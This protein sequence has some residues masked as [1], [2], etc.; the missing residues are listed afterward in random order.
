MD[1]ICSNR[2]RFG[3]IS[4]DTPLYP[5]D[6]YR[7]PCNAK[8][9]WNDSSSSFNFLCRDR[10]PQLY[11]V[12]SGSAGRFKL[13]TEVRMLGCIEFSH[14]SSQPSTSQTDNVTDSG[15]YCDD[16][17]DSGQHNDSNGG[18]DVPNNNSGDSGQH[19]DSDGGN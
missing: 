1:I 19:N 15:D 16:K 12:I 6:P 7:W 18:N 13:I 17:Y 9:S 2:E 5:R 14:C 10:R 8:N 11:Q 4:N 3:D